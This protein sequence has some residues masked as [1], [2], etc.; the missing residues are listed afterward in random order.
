MGLIWLSACRR[1]S[2]VDVARR[3]LAEASAYH[4]A[5]FL[6]L[7]PCSLPPVGDTAGWQA[8]HPEGVRIPSAFVIDSA[9]SDGFSHG[10]LAWKGEHRTYTQVFGHWGFG[11]FE[12]DTLSHQ[13]RVPLGRQT[14]LF[15]VRDSG[16]QYRASAWLVDTLS[17]FLTTLHLATGPTPERLFL[18]RVLPTDPA[19]P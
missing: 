17:N 15:T 19:K 3:Q 12:S 8:T 5:W 4:R 6:A 11:S 2:D 18:L 7:P 16:D 10:G 14:V 9:S 13:C 1:E